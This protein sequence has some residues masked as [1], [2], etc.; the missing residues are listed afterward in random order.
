MP[1]ADGFELGFEVLLFF[2]SLGDPTNAVVAA[3]LGIFCRKRVQ[4]V[5]AA[6]LAPVLSSLGADLLWRRPLELDQLLRIFPH[7]FLAAL[8]WGS[9]AFLLKRQL[10]G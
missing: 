6:L 8:I 2:V 7:M 9:A 4:L 10:R 3:L 1:D 5:V